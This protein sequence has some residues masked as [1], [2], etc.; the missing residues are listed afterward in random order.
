MTAHVRQVYR[1][2]GEHFPGVSRPY[3]DLPE[4]D[5][6]SSPRLHSGTGTILQKGLFPA[7][8]RLAPRCHSLPRQLPPPTGSRQTPLLKGPPDGV[9]AVLRESAKEEDVKP[10]KDGEVLVVHRHRYRK[11]DEKEQPR[12]LVIRSAPDVKLNLVGEPNHA[13]WSRR[14]SG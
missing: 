13:F 2:L 12:F 3:P 1:E 9:Y 8:F 14:W 10:L 11:K 4:E 5:V 6:A 7:L